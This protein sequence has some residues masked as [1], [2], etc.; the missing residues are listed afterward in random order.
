MADAQLSVEL[1]AQVNGFVNAL[2]QAASASSRTDGVVT[3]MSNN[4]S[5]NIANVNRL[6]LSGFQRSLAAGQ[7]SLTR[8]QATVSA[9]PQQLSRL[10]VGSNQAAFALTNLG[11][12]AQDAPFGFIGIQNNL[13]PLL[14]SFQ[15]LRQETG[16]NGAAFRALGQSL[17]GPAGIGI[18]LSV[19]SAAV[20]FYQQY[21]QRANKE[22]EKGEAALKRTKKA[23][24]EYAESLDVVT[25]ARLLGAQKSQEEIAELKAL[26]DITQN[27]IISSKQ[28]GQAVD[29]LQK[30]YPEYFK[31]IKDEAF[32]TG[33]ASEKY[34]ELTV[35]LIATA[36]A[37]AAIDIITTNSK[38]ELIN[39]Q[40]IADLQIQ[41]L[42]NETKLG[43]IRKKD[44]SFNAETGTGGALPF[45]EA[46]QKGIVRDT[47][48]QINDIR[49]DSIKLGQQ[50]LK[51]Q[52][53]ITN[54]VQ[55]GADL[56]GKVGDLPTEKKGKHIKT[57]A[58]VLKEL[59]VDILQ[60]DNSLD[61]TFSE[62]SNKKISAYQ[63]AI[64][65]LIE[66]G[67]SPLNKEII[68]LKEEQYGLF[69]EDVKRKA[70]SF[71][72]SILPQ[73]LAKEASD[74]IEASKKVFEKAV[75]ETR[76]LFDELFTPSASSKINKSDFVKN[77]DLFDAGAA[78]NDTKAAIETLNNSFDQGGVSLDQFKSKY[79]ELTD[80]LK[81]EELTDSLDKLAES[82]INSGIS[83]IGSA[84][85]EALVS[86]G[87]VLE[88]AGKSLLASFGGFLSEYGKLLVAYGAAAILK[89]KLDAA[90]LIPGAG[91]IAGPAAIAA[92]IALQ[93]AGAAI[94]AFASGKGKQ[95]DQY[96][97]V[98]RIPGFANGVNNFGGGLALVG[99]RGPE[100]VN[101]P[102]GSSVIPNGRTEK[103]MRGGNSMINISSELAISGGQL[104][105]L[106][107]AEERSRGRAGV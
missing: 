28:R 97:G 35:S 95:D 6:N 23:A 22:T 5:Q 32:L 91:L 14:E 52:T 7:I 59:N 57:L 40:K 24:E 53:E 64:N 61:L 43:D 101:L 68:K 4:I 71:F 8:L 50:N 66:S 78:I 1:S 10:S 88:A 39:E 104:Y 83:N 58:E 55:K 89:S 16:S 31:N 47:E 98:K 85:G 54:Q 80:T 56:A 92:G 82:F 67:F 12:V 106:I 77:F 46:R 69:S 9:A 2:T 48:K 15:R 105:A 70:D 63:K 86:G 45:E 33:A 37:R 17:I 21:Q 93:V 99:E 26:Y 11:R 76:Q 79:K 90:A 29:D 18:A 30:K 41:Q 51:L 13:N 75:P 19:V 20:L 34:R 103:L 65:N 42:K 49:T 36:R 81:A 72:K 38:R 94:G 107:R 96:N 73:R 102:T 74:K 25:R 87:N 27:N 100:L 3:A 44:A 84:I 60:A 62:V